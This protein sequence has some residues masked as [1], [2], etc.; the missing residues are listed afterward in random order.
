MQSYSERVSAPTEFAPER[1]KAFVDAVVAIAMT[2]L[3]LP[4][5]EAVSEAADEGTSTAEFLAQHS[6]QLLSFLL[7]FVMIAMFWME[8]HA[9]YQHVE[10]ITTPLLWINVAWMLTI[11]WLPVPTSM[12]GQMSG[13]PLQAFLYIGTLTMTQVSTLA[14]KLYFLRHP[15]CIDLDA[16]ALRRGAS[17]DIAAIILF[18]IALPIAAWVHVIGYFALVLIAFVGP[19]ERLLLR[20]RG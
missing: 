16:D 2:L 15:D 5:L 9:L 7:S 13:D 4:L 11:V 12:L 8:H 1:M 6:G 20:A 14:G 18:A 17:G 19:L 10:R 3:I